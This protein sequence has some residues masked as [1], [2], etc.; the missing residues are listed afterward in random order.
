MLF[1][2]EG[3]LLGSLHSPLFLNDSTGGDELDLSYKCCVGHTVSTMACSPVC[4]ALES[5]AT[6][7]E[8][9]GK[10]IY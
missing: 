8:Y 7:Q 6:V 5:V 2:L 10:L 1:L 3:R 4:I 9:T